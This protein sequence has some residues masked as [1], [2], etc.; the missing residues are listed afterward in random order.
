MKYLSLSLFGKGH[1]PKTQWKLGQ[2]DINETVTYRYLGDIVSNDGKNT[3]NI[4]SRKGKIT[5][6]TI[7]INTIA[8][9][10]TLRCIETAVLL[11]L[12]EKVNIPALLA[13]AEAWVLNKNEIK[14]IERTEVQAMKYLFDLPAHTPT[15]GIIFSLGIPYTSHRIEQKRFLYLYH[16]LTQP[17][18]SWVKRTLNQMNTLNIGWAKDINIALNEYNLYTDYSIISNLTKR[19]WTRIVKEK[20]ETKNK[21][22]LL[23]DCY[24]TENGTTTLK[25]K[26]AHLAS[27]LREDNYERSPQKELALCTK[28]ETKTLIIARFGMLECGVNFKGTMRE[29]CRTCNTLD[30]EHHRLNECTNYRELNFSNEDTKVNFQDVFSTD[31]NVLRNVIP[32]IQQVWNVKNAHGTMNK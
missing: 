24:K 19:Q 29:I 28:Q 15:L 17:D 10:D 7:G 27:I 2:L 9:S 3:H 25:T 30:N 8:S 14:E 26:T 11:E 18:H 23:D 12:H 32:K 1:D 4:E 5:A 6:A 31:I 21:R 16:I 22:R 20:I 13:N